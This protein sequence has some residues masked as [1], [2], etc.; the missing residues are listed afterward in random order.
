VVIG[1]AEDKIGDQEILRLV[2]DRVG[3]G[4]LVVMTCATEDPQGAWKRYRE[5]F[6]KLGA[7]NLAHVDIRDRTAAE[8]AE[9]SEPIDGAKAVFFTG[10]DQLRITS[11]IGGTAAYR[12]ILKVLEGGGIVAGTSAGAAVMS[13]T[14]LVE[15]R[16]ENTPKV[17]DIVRMA[18]GLGLLANIVVDMHFSERGR[19]GRL[20]GA[21][22]QNPRVLGIGIDEDTAAL[23]EG[24]V[25]TVVGSGAI[26]VVDGRQSA[27]AN[28][29]EVAADETLS[30]ENVTLHVLGGGRRYDL[31]RRRPL[32]PVEQ[33]QAA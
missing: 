24:D 1:G 13:G 10:G 8:A 16:S 17:G 6:T 11:H 22:A 4:R 29:A 15:G 26:Y 30:I 3:R 19:L 5:I 23:I 33:A 9:V 2:A 31:E 21:V 28:V 32:P 14:M 7:K 20:I 27:H 18:P 25:M 12:R